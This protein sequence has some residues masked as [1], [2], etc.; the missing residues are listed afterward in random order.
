[1]AKI[2]FDVGQYEFRVKRSRTGLGLF[3]A[4]PIARGRCV[5]EYTGCVLSKEEEYTSNSKYLF[6]VNRNKTIDGRGKSNIARYINHSC[7]PNCEIEISR[8]RV[9]VMAKRAI[10]PGEE[11]FYDYG[12]EYFA[13]HIR[14]KACKCAKCFPPPE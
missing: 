11:L 14:P 3:T 4:D 12:P 2:K 7:R 13:K 6:E 10:K 1:M 9:Y 8:G 5:V